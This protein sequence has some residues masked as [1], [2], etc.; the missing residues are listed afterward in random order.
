MN[1]HTP[2]LTSCHILSSPSSCLQPA[3]STSGSSREWQRLP[4]EMVSHDESW[5]HPGAVSYHQWSCMTAPRAVMSLGPCVP[6]CWWW[7]WCCYFCVAVTHMRM[8]MCVECVHALSV[9]D[10]CVCACACACARA[11]VCVSTHATLVS[12]WMSIFGASA[13]PL[14]QH[15]PAT[16]LM[17]LLLPSLHFCCYCHPR[18]AAAAASAL[19][20]LLLLMPMPSP[21]CCC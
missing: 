5:H 17:A 16:A 1:M 14:M 11:C 12:I 18:L 2:T 4:K 19:T 8:R 13:L 21:S 6:N 3:A 20:T 15:L 9:R 10:V 7:W